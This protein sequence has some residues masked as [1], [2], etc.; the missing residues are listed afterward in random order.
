V[1]ARRADLGGYF[2]VTRSTNVATASLYS[3]PSSAYAG[4]VVR[5]SLG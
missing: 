3:G 2:L 5:N 4:A 1:R